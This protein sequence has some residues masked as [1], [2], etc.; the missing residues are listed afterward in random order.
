M[1]RL[2]G[3]PPFYCDDDDELKELILKAEV[4]FPATEWGSISASTKAT[5]EK[6]LQVEPNKR[7]GATELLRSLE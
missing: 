2:C 4:K 3:Y 7:I 6:M 1:N 5:I